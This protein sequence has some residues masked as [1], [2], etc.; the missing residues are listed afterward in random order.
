MKMLDK[1]R[2]FGD[3]SVSF[4]IL[5]DDIDQL[6]IM[7]DVIKSIGRE[8]CSYEVHKDEIT[9]YMMELRLPYNRYLAMM[10]GLR[11]RGWNLKP[12]SKADVIKRMIRD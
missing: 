9:A 5:F 7:A 6:S 2:D 11:K 12:E 8:R 10:K 1:I 3:V 4:V